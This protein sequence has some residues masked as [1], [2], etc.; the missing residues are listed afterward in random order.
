MRASLDVAVA[1]PAPV[2]ATA[3]AGRLYGELDRIDRLLDGLL[4]L[5]RAQHGK[6]PGCAVL[7]LE[8]IASASLAARGEAIRARNLTVSRDGS[9]DG[10]WV[11]GSEELVRRMVDNL[12]E[13]VWD[14]HADPFTST[15]PV[16]TGRLRRKLG[17]P[18]V[19]MTTPGAGYRIA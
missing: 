16:T 15:V 6:L 18:P 19:V 12:L 9:P 8:A 13:Q 11:T 1:K 17:E 3:V 5:A 14:E 7:S 4:V 2:P 10:A